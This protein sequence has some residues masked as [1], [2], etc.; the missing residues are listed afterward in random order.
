MFFFG[1]TFTNSEIQIQ[2][3]IYSELGVTP[4]SF[5]KPDYLAVT[6]LVIVNRGISDISLLSEC[7]N[8]RY[9]NLANNQVEDIST[10]SNL[11]ELV[12]LD[13]QGNPV[14]KFFKTKKLENLEVFRASNLGIIDEKNLQEFGKLKELWIPGSSLEDDSF[15]KFMPHLE[16]LNLSASKINN[17]D[18]IYKLKN[19]KIC[20]LEGN[21]GFDRQVENRILKNNKDCMFR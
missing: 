7:Q 2:S 8:L 10:L 15:L 17:F 19:L 4:E 3:S 21:P 11:R 18:A 13:L 20:L 12:V 16:V 9:L 5:S 6:N 14:S 1:K